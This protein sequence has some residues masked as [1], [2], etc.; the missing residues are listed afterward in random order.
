MTGGLAALCCGLWLL[1]TTR[2]SGFVVQRA[3]LQP[4]LPP[5]AHAAAGSRA[6][7]PRARH[8][9]ALTG[10]GT[11][12]ATGTG[13]RRRGRSPFLQAVLAAEPTASAAAAAAATA[14]VAA[15][16]A[17]SPHQEE[18]A[19]ED[20][21][22]LFAALESHTRRKEAFEELWNSDMEFSETEY[23]KLLKACFRLGYGAL[24]PPPRCLHRMSEPA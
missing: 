24:P 13:Q 6:W 11:G 12:T 10:T 21:G 14:A 19:G 16:A 2:C 9:D 22:A 15:A 17:A 20:K 5:A 18:S 7:L 23:Q 8:S 4:V 3:F 1:V